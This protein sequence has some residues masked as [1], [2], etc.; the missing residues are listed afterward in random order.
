MADVKWIKITTDIFDDDKIKL[1]DSLPDRDAILVIW[2]KLLTLAGK[3]NDDGQAYILKKIPTTAEILSTVFNRPINTIRL[4]L[5]TFQDFDMVEIEDHINIINWEK[6]QNIEGLDKIREQNRLRKQKQR[7]K[8]LP[9][10]VTVTGRHATEEDKNRLELDKNKKEEKECPVPYRDII[11]LF[12][13]ITGQNLRTVK[14]SA[15]SKRHIK[16]RFNDGFTIEDFQHVITVKNAEW[17]NDNKSKPWIRPSTLF[18]P[19]FESYLQQKGSSN[20]FGSETTNQGIF[21]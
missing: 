4:A 15:D 12:N 19:K 9:C 14:I 21:K 20:I 8:S 1:I 11:E 7:A 3:V 16:A 5:N 13:S 18:G 2:F 10:P 6:H 17:K